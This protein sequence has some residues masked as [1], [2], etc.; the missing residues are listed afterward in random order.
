MRERAI[1]EN[2]GT[3]ETGDEKQE[4]AFGWALAYDTRVVFP[5]WMSVHSGKAAG[6]DQSRS[7]REPSES[8][9]FAV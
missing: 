3:L 8:K 1:A 5:K 6:P 7:T 9:R 4:R 2:W